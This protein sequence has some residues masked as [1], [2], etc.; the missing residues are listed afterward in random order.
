MVLFASRSIDGSAAA[1]CCV[2]IHVPDLPFCY[3]F[4]EDD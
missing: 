4:E 1:M 3:E 2:A